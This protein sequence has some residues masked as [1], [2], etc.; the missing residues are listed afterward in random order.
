MSPGASN[1]DQKSLVEALIEGMGES[2]FA[3]DRD[4]RFT[5]SN[6]AAEAILGLPRAELIGRLLWDILPQIKGTEFDRRC[7]RVLEEHAREEFEIYSALRPDRYH[8]VR[9]F[10]FGDGVGVTFRDITDRQKDTLALRGRELELARVQRIGGVG[11]LEVDLSHGF[12]SQRSPEY[13][14]LHGLPPSAVNDTH[15]QWVAR[16]HPEDRERV[17]KYF[18]AAVAGSDRDY[19]AEYR[20][21]R[22]SD[23]EI[24]WIR[25]VA[26]IE[27]DIQGRP[28]RLVG[29]HLD[30]TDQ[31]RAEEAIQESEGRLRAIADALPFLISYLDGDQIFRFIN[32]PYEAWFERPL[33]EIVGHSVSEVMGPAMYKARRP[34]IERALAGERL[35]YEADFP[36][37]GGTV[38]TEIVHIPHRD[39]GGHILGLYTVVMDVTARKLAERVLSESEERFRSIADSAPVPMWVSRLDGLRQFVNRAYHEFLGV[40]FVDALNFDWRKALHPD[41]LERVLGEQRAGEGSRK[42]FVLEARYRR[43]DGQWRWLRSESQ[44]RWGPA[45]EHIGF[46]GVAHDITASKEAERALTEL[47]ETL[48][49]RI[50]DR[51]QQLAASEALI[52]TFFK[53][54]SECHAVIV[55]DSDGRFRYAEVNPAT[56]RLYGKTREEVVGRTLEAVLGVAGAAE[57]GAHLAACLQAGAPYRYERTLDD[58]VIEA[59]VTAAPQEPGALRR[60]IVSAHDV[61]ERRRLAQQLQQSQKMEALGQLTGGV[62]HD[63]NNLLT[64]VVGGLDIIGR[65]MANLPDPL[66]L[67]RMERGRDMAMQGARR[68]ASLTTRLLT[69][70]RQQALTPQALDANKLVAD[71]CELLR[72]TLGETI[73]LETMLGDGLWRTYADANQLE[74]AL[75]NLGLNARDA[76]PV[77]GRLVIETA[78]ALLDKAYVSSLNESIEPGEFVLIAVTDTGAGM[79]KTT[80]ERAFEP[81]FTTKEVGKGTGLGLSQVYGFARQSAGHVRIYSEI[82]EG[83]TVKIYLP[84]SV[85]D[86]EKSV[87]DASNDVSRWTGR[88]RI[89]VVEDDDSLRG[90][91]SEILE[92]LGYRVLSASDGVA[93]L[94]ILGREDRIDLL[95]TD[96]VMPGGLNGRQLADKATFLRPFLRVL[97]MTGYTRDP[98]IHQGRLD[99]EINLI[100]KPFSFKELAAKVRQRLDAPD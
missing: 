23:G 61:T 46:I 50:E 64:L 83:T 34:F 14:Y 52:Q 24:R 94:E 75:L 73:V 77:G 42:P 95:L 27:R 43:H 71:V 57:I 8:D 20:I 30:I 41:D 40:S 49:R 82:G 33:S 31:K 21:V 80:Q 1:S 26:E 58:A 99:A 92:E 48:E 89:L 65:Q 69:F 25:A 36:R 79:D 13:L 88:E 62:A 12:R 98:I 39:A 17:E 96:V 38:Q 10:P 29:A 47:N 5:A 56:L 91:A 44:P 6:S 15:E 18:L 9:A 63:F 59:I 93:A 3:F 85:S 37:S 35:S 19:K 87:T 68:A 70:S 55:E 28:Q 76:M 54:S 81:F 60:V 53:H 4:C 100:S 2:F 7:R 86:A 51:T 78:N 22:P 90:Y 67:T 16:I 32:K 11:G 66:A 45:G 72:R 74:N 84:R 97:Y